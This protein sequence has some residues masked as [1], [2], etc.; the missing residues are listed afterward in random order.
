MASPHG[1]DALFHDSDGEHRERSA[2][3]DEASGGGPPTGTAAET[4]AIE[5]KP[6]DTTTCG[7]GSDLLDTIERLSKSSRGT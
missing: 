3:G 5:E 7:T 2:C 1:D 6:G 4:P